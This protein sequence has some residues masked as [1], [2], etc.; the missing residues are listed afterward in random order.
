MNNNLT[1]T[2]YDNLVKLYGPEDLVELRIVGVPYRGVIAGYFHDKVALAQAAANYNEQGS[3]YIML[4]PVKD[5]L[6]G[7]THNRIQVKALHTANDNDIPCRRYLFVDC[8][9]VRPKGTSSTDEEH[10][11]AL[12]KAKLIRDWLMQEKGH[13]DM[14]MA[15]SGNGAHLVIPVELPNDEQTDRLVKEFLLGLAKTF[16]DNAVKIDTSV[17]NASRL[18][19]LW[20]TMAIKGRDLPER[21]HRDSQLLYA[22]KMVH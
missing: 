17:H 22:P 3:I 2:I 14:F 8:D 15:D 13:N 7:R 20:G 5:E 19:K 9:P 4:N 12:A 6:K 1:T 16:D 21:R 18:I 11:L 10:N